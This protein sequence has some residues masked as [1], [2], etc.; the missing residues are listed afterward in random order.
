MPPS[1]NPSSSPPTKSEAVTQGESILAGASIGV[2]DLVELV[3]RL[4]KERAFGLARKILDRY[5]VKPEVKQHPDLKLRLKFAQKRSLCTYKDPDLSVDDRLDRALG[6]LEEVDPLEVSKDQETLGQAGAIYKRKW[7][8]NGSAAHLETSLAYYLRGFNEGVVK[9]FGY[10]AINAAFVLE[11]LAET[12]ESGALSAAAS[13]EL[14][15]ARR[16]QAKTIRE[17]IVKVLPELPKQAD[18]TWL[19]NEWWFLVT[20]GEA[21]FGL[22]DYDLAGEWL[23]KAAALPKVPDWE[24][25]TTARQMSTLLRLQKKT[26]EAKGQPTNLDGERVLKEFLCGNF[27]AV[28]SIMQGKIGLALSGGGFRASL[29]HIGVLARLA[30]LDILRSIE[31]LSCVSGGSI[32]GAH[33]YLE[34][35]HLLQTKTDS[36]ITKQDYI[37]IVHR[38]AH[39]F[40]G[41]VQRN[42]RTRI[43]AEW[44]TNLKMIFL[45]DYSRTLRAGELYESDIFSRVKDGEGGNRWLNNLYVRPK[46]DENLVPKDNNWRRSNKVPILIL[47]ATTLNTGHNWQFTASWMGEPPAGA[48]KEIDANYRLR[49]MYYRDLPEGKQSIRLGQAVAASACVP[50]LFE[51]L[52]LR[53]I[54]PRDGEPITVRLVDGGVHD[55]QGVAALLEQSCNVLLISDAS[56]QMDSQNNPSAGV[57]GVPLR[58]NTILQTRVRSAQYRELEARRR[59]GLL[60][61][62]MFVHLKK[63]LGAEPV[64]WIDCQE[65][66][67]PVRRDPLLEYGIQR[68]VQ[69]RLAAI[70]TDLDSFSEA[71]AYALMTSGYCMA[72]KALGESALGFPISA[73]PRENWEFLKIE[74][75]MKQPGANT[76]LMRQLKVAEK[77]AFRIWLL[78]R[79]LKIGAI[80]VGLALL[81]WIGFLAYA[82]WSVIAFSLTV[83]ALLT[84]VICAV[85]GATGWRFLSKVIQYRKMFQSILIGIGM[86]TAGWLLA[87]LHLHVFDRIFL[88]QGSLAHLLEE[89]E[90]IRMRGRP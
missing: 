84:T 72:E 28:T 36:E 5:A 44:L 14:A 76:P 68:E 9:D 51:P 13:S 21:C 46:G 41:G 4:K 38:L 64:D 2:A 22:E 43:A 33:Y 53:G 42:I 74:P 57:L 10:T 55:N 40:L 79:A 63:D 67:D 81:V 18:K 85:L 65:L 73:A 69:R 1:P 19:N 8:L 3:N 83:G 49:R 6:I 26:W 32:I 31:Y 52:S 15:K 82:H 45:S 17:D 48:D 77:Q 90:T 37:E 71:E 56:G 78:S 59:S 12:A 27:A 86:G 88:R 34:V 11:L 80:G 70:R 89:S 16:Q 75:L 54:Y 35:R 47:N 24:W 60:R 66:T 25:E 61:G 20:L 30:E 50:G 7:E 23:K 29:Y 58:S 39:D 87:R 62:L